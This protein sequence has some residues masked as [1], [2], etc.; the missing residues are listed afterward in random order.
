MSKSHPT[1]YWFSTF[2]GVALSDVWS[3]AT[4]RPAQ[5][6]FTSGVE[7]LQTRSSATPQCGKKHLRKSLSMKHL[8]KRN[9]KSF[10]REITRGE[11]C[12]WYIK[13]RLSVFLSLHSTKRGSI[14]MLHLH[15]ECQARLQAYFGRRR[16]YRPHSRNHLVTAYLEFLYQR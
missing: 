8:S 1:P 11:F 4:Q 9:T 5:R 12:A 2:C 15:R 13:E 3:S 14:A 7:P 10:L 16:A 6:H